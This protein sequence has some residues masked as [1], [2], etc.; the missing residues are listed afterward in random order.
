M[1]TSRYLTI[2]LVILFFTTSCGTKKQILPSS[3]GLKTPF[4]EN[5]NHSATYGEAIDYYEMLSQR[6]DRIKVFPFG[7]TDSGHPLHEVIIDK[8]KLFDPSLSKASGKAIMMVNNA[9]HPGEPCGVDASMMLA[10]EL[11][12]NDDYEKLLEHTVVVILPFYNIS[13]GL[14]RGSYSRAN[15]NGPKEY[16]FRGNAQNLDLNRDFIKADTRNAESFNKLFNKWDPDVFIDNHTSNGADYQYVITLIATQ[17]DK[18]QKDLSKYMVKEMLPDLYKGMEKSGYEMTPYVNSR[19]TPDEG[20][21][22]FL[23]LPRYSSGYAALHHSL[24]F[25]PETHM[26]KP[27]KDRVWS[28]F[29]FMK[30]VLLHLDE[31]HE[32]IIKVRLQAK[33]EYAFGK[34]HDINWTLDF[35]KTDQLEFKGYEAGYKESK[36]TGQSRLYYDR[37]KPY[38]KKVPYYNTYKATSTIE[39][40]KGYIIPHA[41]RQVINRLKWNKVEMVQLESDTILE[42]VQ[43]KID[44]YES[45]K[46]PYEGHYL[47]YNVEVTPVEKEMLV[48]KGDYIINTGQD[49]D[50]YLIETLEPHAPDSYFAWNF[51]DGILGMKEYFSSYVFEER[52]EELLKKDRKLRREFEKKKNEDEEFSNDARAQLRFI[53]ERSPHYEQQYMHYPILR[54]E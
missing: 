28:V 38:T 1:M 19:G 44:N 24:S 16:G 23:D 29:L 30:H 53:Y 3:T 33:K 49:K 2:L 14:N 21:A 17:K 18:L 47:H 11:M 27:F 48:R 9:I 12:E 54:I 31:N 25:M 36:V 52:A 10:R 6:Y 32:E 15:Q 51:M 4:E 13:G 35:D 45:R 46:S 8:D 34:K 50:R 22:G 39:K 20:I 37:D 40:P 26:L 7:L 43:Y 42:V 41:Y 5:D